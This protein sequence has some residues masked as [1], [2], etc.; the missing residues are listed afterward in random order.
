MFKKL[1]NRLLIVNT[2]I[3]AALVLGSFSVIYFTTWQNTMHG[4]DMKL[5][6]ALEM[7]AGR[8][9][10]MGMRENLPAPDGEHTP[11]EDARPD[12][13][14]NAPPE[15]RQDEMF[16][17]TFTVLTDNDGN[18]TKVNMPF[19]MTDDFYS[20]KL[21]EIIASPKDRSMLKSDG[22]CW[23]Y[24]K[25]RNADGYVIAFTDTNAE[26][27]IMRNLLI[28][29]S[30][31]ALAALAAAFLIS[32][33]SANKSIKPVEESYNRQKRFVADASHE[34]KTPLTT[35]NTNADVLLSHE[36]STIKE[37]KKWI[38]YIKTETERMTKLT[39][40]LLYLARL[41][42]DEENVML[43]PVSFSQAAESV[44]LLM[45]AVVFEKDIK[46]T[47]D[48]APDII[49]NGSSEQLCQLVMILLDNACKYTPPKG[50]IEIKLFKSASDAVL[51]V[52]N[53]GDGISEEALKHIFERF[54]REDTSRARE[55]GGYGLGLAIA[56]AV[57]N[58]HKGSI[59]AQ[60][61]K[62]G[63]TRFTVKI[64]LKK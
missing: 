8:G 60:S 21:G 11:P 33:F 14:K 45:E 48:I 54:Y 50:S 6:R 12:G 30:L 17:L 57:T 55:S 56:Q 36:D 5:D 41:D 46:M 2:L 44:I 40:D 49:V 53:S 38:D 52:C 63:F 9:G 62:N 37:E 31:V 29:L 42:H 64:P 1:R 59:K 28:I 4:V 25:V 18:I 58:A 13:M 27:T 19:D 16:T 35:I 20:D 43:A 24:R 10:H 34:L 32:L 47:Y 22:N 23:T 61:E 7:T 26:Q 3:I 39:N 51:T 15:T